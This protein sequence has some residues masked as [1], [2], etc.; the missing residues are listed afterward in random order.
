MKTGMV[1]VH[2]NDSK[3]VSDLID[4]I[5]DYKILDKIVIV[6]NKSNDINLSKVKKL[7]NKKI[8]LIENKDNKGFAYA[9][10]VG[11]KYLIKTLGKCNLIVSNAD[12][13]IDKEKNIIDLIKYLNDDEIGLVSPTIIENGKLNR[14]WRNPTPLM[15]ILMNMVYI[16]R[17]IRKKY[18]FYSN[19]HYKNK[20]SDVEVVSGCF[21]LLKSETLEEINYLDENTFLYYEENILAKKIKNINKRIIVCNDI[22][23]IHNHSIS[24]DKNLKKIKKFK[25][26]KKSQYYFQTEYNKANIIE[27]ILLKVTAFISRNILGVLYYIK[28]LNR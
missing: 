6:D 17:F 11:C 23:I 19:E 2:Y 8:E 9:I 21:F 12:I 1:I 10:N 7:C 15:D 24:I 18:I 16:H 5:K 20:I 27:R 4:N 13:I 26:Q 22:K 14:G 3:S 28:D 25:T